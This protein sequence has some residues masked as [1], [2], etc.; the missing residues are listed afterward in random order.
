MF[1][2][3]GNSLI[4]K[5]NVLG[6][7]KSKTSIILINKPL[8]LLSFF[9][10]FYGAEYYYNTEDECTKAF[11][12]IQLHDILTDYTNKRLRQGNNLMKAIKKAD[13]NDIC[14]KNEF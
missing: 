4:N 1:M 11:K 6:I 2:R 9:R 10:F 8:T 13:N 14:K 3:V 12:N 7:I 5:N